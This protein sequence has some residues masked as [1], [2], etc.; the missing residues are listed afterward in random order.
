[1]N[2]ALFLGFFFV[3]RFPTLFFGKEIGREK[4]EDNIHCRGSGAC[5]LDGLHVDQDPRCLEHHH[6]SFQVSLHI[7]DFI[8]HLVKCVVSVSSA[9]L[10]GVSGAM[11]QQE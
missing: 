2:H 3:L 10:F 1:M 4:H 5:P 11:G 7:Q 9:H 6:S 8:V